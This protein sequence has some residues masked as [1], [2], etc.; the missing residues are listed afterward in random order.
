MDLIA[1]IRRAFSAP[2]VV[3]LLSVAC[4]Q[5]WQRTMNM[6]TAGT[7]PASLVAFHGAQG[8]FALVVACALLTWRGDVGLPSG[9]ARFVMPAIAFAAPFVCYA[10]GLWD[11]WAL[12]LVGSA[13][14]G[15]GLVWCYILCLD[16]YRRFH[17]GQAVLFGVVAFA[18]AAVVRVPLAALDAFQTLLLLSPLPLVCYFLWRRSLGIPA[19]DAGTAGGKA[20]PPAVSAALVSEAVI[21]GLVSGVLRP[22]AV[23]GQSRVS[24]LILLAL[25]SLFLLWWVCRRDRA[26]SIGLV[27]QVALFVTL[28]ALLAL[29]VFGG[30]SSAAPILAST[31][32]RSTVYLLMWV[33]VLG[34]AA[35]GCRRLFLC[36]ALGWGCFEGAYAAGVV[37]GG[38]LGSPP[39]SP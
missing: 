15:V 23:I 27:C 38:W 30:D 4:P 19:A 10:G 17:V 18:L 37:L 36:F 26:V 14:G 39:P 12:T 28:T 7:A 32:I 9:P 20:L 35:A 5:L 22:V 21:Y 29:Y 3:C 8:L 11:A 2:G 1:R 25:P 31:S 16:I 24:A 34:M 13:L 33:S 6:L